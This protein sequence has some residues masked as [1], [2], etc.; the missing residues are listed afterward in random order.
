MDIVNHLNTY[1]KFLKL[2]IVKLLFILINL[3]NI[4]NNKEVN[5]FNLIIKI[6]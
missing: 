4:Y 1:Y 3:F 2:N 5:F 6:Y